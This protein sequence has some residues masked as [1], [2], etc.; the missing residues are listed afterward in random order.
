MTD[1]PLVWSGIW[2]LG[3]RLDTLSWQ[4][5][6]PGVKIHRLYGDGTQGPAAALLWYEPG[7]EV[8]R[9]EHPGYEHI[10]VLSGSQ[11]DQHQTYP[12]G[13]LVIN[14][15]A[16]DHKV[17]SDEGCLVLVIWQQPVNILDDL[18]T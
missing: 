15:P 10:I 14:S 17:I 9:H 2:S 18:A 6:R 16:T 11:R 3:D 5:F 12:A 4:A 1:S 7:A 13:S 8:P